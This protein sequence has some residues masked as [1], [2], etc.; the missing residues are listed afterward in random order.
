MQSINPSSIKY[1]SINDY[2][3]NMEGIG[4]H[5]WI[6]PTSF[7]YE[8]SV[9]NNGSETNWILL[10]PVRKSIPILQLEPSSTKSNDKIHPN[11][12]NA[13]KVSQATCGVT[14]F[15]GHKPRAS[16]E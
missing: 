2:F 1:V 9:D 3:Q 11:W 5:L 8:T 15:T 12:L 10:Y 7:S 13:A 4:I 16:A 6:L 14:D